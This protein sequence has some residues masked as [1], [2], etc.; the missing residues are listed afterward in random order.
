MTEKEV[1]KIIDSNKVLPDD[2]DK[3]KYFGFFPA[4]AVTLA[5]GIPLLPFV[6]DKTTS[7]LLIKWIGLV[8]GLLLILLTYLSFKNEKKLKLINTNLDKE[9][10]QKIIEEYFKKQD[11]PLTKHTNYYSTFLPTLFYKE[12]LKL[13]IIPWNNKIH[14]NIRTIGFAVE[15]GRIPYSI[16]KIIQQNKLTENLKKLSTTLYKNNA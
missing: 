13:I 14:Y 6:I 2:L 8:I 9:S 12:G 3:D 7:N 11:F 16:G 5:F 10:N 4:V 1:K 15:G